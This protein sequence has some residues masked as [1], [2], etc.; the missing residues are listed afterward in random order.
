M[1]TAYI[2]VYIWKQAVQAAGTTEVEKVKRYAIGQE[3]EAPEGKITMGANHH[4][5]KYVRIGRVNT[6]GLFDIIMETDVVP[7]QP[8]N[9]FIPEYAN[10]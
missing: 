5:S 4:L 9:K 2:A 8:W 3:F 6:K 10:N 1:E 7:A